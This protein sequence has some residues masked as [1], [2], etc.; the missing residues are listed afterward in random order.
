MVVSSELRAAALIND[1]LTELSGCALATAKQASS[2]AAELGSEKLT[3][4]VPIRLHLLPHRPHHPHAG[5]MRKG[6]KQQQA[7]D[8]E[9]QKLTHTQN[10]KESRGEEQKAAAG[11]EKERNHTELT[12]PRG[13]R[14]R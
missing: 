7:I 6:S 12:Q 10:R 8:K 5:L 14:I 11:R 1:I 3:L 9:T 4:A 13:K 2:L